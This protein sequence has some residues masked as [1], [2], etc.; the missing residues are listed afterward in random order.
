MERNPTVWRK[1]EKPSNPK[2]RKLLRRKI[3][4]NDFKTFR[5]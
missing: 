1:I 3:D 2:L 5:S 4:L